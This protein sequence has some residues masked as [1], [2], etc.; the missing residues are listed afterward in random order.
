[1]VAT[2]RRIACL[3]GALVLVRLVIV[4]V[5]LEGHATQGKQTVLPGDVRRFHR[6]ANHAGTPYR[7]FPVEYPPLTVAAIDALNGR[8][9]RE[10]TVNV[11][12]SQ[13]VLDLAI[14]AVM[15]WGWGRKAAVLYLLIGLAFIWYPFLYL[16]LDLLS[17]FLAVTG[18]ALV[19]RRRL[20]SGPGM[21]ALAC[22]AKVWP[23]ALAPTLL[24]RQS[25]RSLIAF[26]T[27]GI[28]GLGA[29][30]A[31]GGSDAPVQV[32]TF[33]GARGW[34]IESTVG[35][36]VHTAFS[37]RTYFEAGAWRTGIAPAWAR[38]GLPLFGLAL[39][40][41]IWVLANRTRSI[42]PRIVDGL[43]SVGVIA[44]LLV[45]ATVLSPQYASWLLPFAA[46]AAAGGERAVGWLTAVIGA[47]STLG[48]DLVRELGAGDGFPASIVLVRNSLL[49]V[50]LGLVTVRLHRMRHH[51]P[52]DSDTDTVPTG[53]RVETVPVQVGE[54]FEVPAFGTSRAVDPYSR[55]T[56]LS[57][58]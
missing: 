44:A 45:T 14:A 6:I 58:L 50:L 55:P 52:P 40:A 18:M 33:R 23:I 26:A 17:V 11:M 19:R 39:G 3:V 8:T 25:W 10:S 54:R 47:L 31:F 16:R 43:A 32:L 28:A 27:V 36:F 41:G 56:R 29:W 34:Q 15:A 2:P 5:A 9:V 57:E 7:D 53:R 51:P 4:G 37:G 42:E 49:W 12:W 35:A 24:V 38:T 20:L 22:F 30:I 21:L 1:M 46:I 48:F 13:V